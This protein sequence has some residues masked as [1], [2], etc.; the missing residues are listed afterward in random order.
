MWGTAATSPGLHLVVGLLPAVHGFGPI[1]GV[2][3]LPRWKGIPSADSQC[4][5]ECFLFG[6]GT[7]LLLGAWSP[8]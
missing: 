2:L 5:S 3:L 8:S 4:S 6:I 1:Q 7:I